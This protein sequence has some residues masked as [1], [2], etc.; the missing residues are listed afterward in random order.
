MNANENDHK[1]LYSFMFSSQ[2]G[3]ME[4]SFFLQDTWVPT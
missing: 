1:M 4:E 3:Q 2:T